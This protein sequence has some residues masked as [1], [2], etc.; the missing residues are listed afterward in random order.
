MATLVVAALIVSSVEAEVYIVT[1]EGDPVVRYRGSI[2]GFEA[3]VV[4]KQKFDS[5][6]FGN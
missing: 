6:R 5:T 4:S 2:P 3:T 1:V